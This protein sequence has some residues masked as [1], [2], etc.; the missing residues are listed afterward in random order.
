M[1]KKKSIMI[2][3]DNKEFVTLL[4]DYINLQDDMEVVKCHY[5]GLNA[6]E[7]IKNVKPDVLLLDIIMPEKDG[8]AVLEELSSENI[9]IPLIIIMSSIG[10]ERITQ[11]AISLG[12]TYYVIKPFDMKNI[13][14]RIRDLLETDIVY[15]SNQNKS[16]QKLDSMLVKNGISTLEVRVTNAIHDVGVPAHIKGYQFVR[17]AIIMAVNNEEIINSVTKTLYPNLSKMF[18]TTPSRVERAIRHAI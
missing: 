6:V 15:E 12:A 13:V 7:T 1:D 8:I 10:Q 14:T 18:Q 17:E 5:D 11:K 9:K 2:V 16:Q 4:N 3:D